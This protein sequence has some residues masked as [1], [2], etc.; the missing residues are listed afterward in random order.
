MA[1]FASLLEYLFMLQAVIAAFTCLVRTDFN[2]QI[3]GMFYAGK[4]AIYCAE[5]SRKGKTLGRNC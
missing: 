1:D 2:S 5:T 4:W 3:S